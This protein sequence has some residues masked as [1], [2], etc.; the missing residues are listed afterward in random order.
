[1]PKSEC[2]KKL[3]RAFLIALIKTLISERLFVQFINIDNFFNVITLDKTQNAQK[4]PANMTNFY[5]LGILNP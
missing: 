5:Q 2:D 3:F 1:M 4:T